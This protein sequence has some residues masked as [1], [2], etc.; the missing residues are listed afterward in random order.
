MR[1]SSF[2]MF[3]SQQLM[4]GFSLFRLAFL[5]RFVRSGLQVRDVRDIVVFVKF[6]AV[7]VPGKVPRGA[8]PIEGFPEDDFAV[9]HGIGIQVVE[10]GR[11]RSAFNDRDEL[12]VNVQP[13]LRVRG[14][15]CGNERRKVQK[16]ERSDAQVI[17]LGVSSCDQSE[18]CSPLSITL[19]RILRTSFW[20]EGPCVNSW[21]S[22]HKLGWEAR[23][24]KERSTRLGIS[25]QP[26]LQQR[27]TASP[28]ETM[29]EKMEG[30]EKG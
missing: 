24:M 3:K 12:A 18:H 21:T 11:A 9:V 17:C 4:R 25:F 26:N 1:Y 27:R 20:S 8:T 7:H 2:R 14:A 6:P 5:C 16:R 19:P 30:E 22:G 23:A 10:Y 29:I 28:V 15:V 13:S